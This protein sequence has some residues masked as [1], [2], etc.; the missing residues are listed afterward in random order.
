MK[1]SLPW[2]LLFAV[3]MSSLPLL[4][5]A[6]SLRIFIFANFI[7]IFA[8][9][10]DILSGYTGYISFGHPFLIGIAGYTSAI[11]THQFA[12]PLYVSMPLAILLTLVAGSLFF[13]PALRTR[14]TYFA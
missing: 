2:W 13:F 9:S 12:A 5:S 11:L 14:G 4:I 3:I 6:G 10:W 8:M 7:A 1:K